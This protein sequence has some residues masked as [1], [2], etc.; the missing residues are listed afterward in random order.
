MNAETQA[1]TL[2]TFTW[3]GS[4]QSGAK[5]KGEMNAINASIIKA[6]LQ[7]QGIEPTRIRKKSK[8]LFT[9]RKRNIK[10]TEVMLFSRHLATMVTAGLPLV[11]ALDTV[12]RG[13]ENPSMQTLIMTI[14]AD[15]EGG[16]TF[17]DA[18]KQHPKQFDDLFCNLISAGEVSGT[19]DVML[20][21][22]ATYQEKSNSLKKKVKKAMYYPITILLVA[23]VVTGVLLVFVVPQF[24]ELFS[25]FGASLPA[26]TQMVLSLSRFLQSYWFAVFGG[27][28]ALVF[29]FKKLKQRSPRFVAWL[30]A[31]VLKM[32][33][34]GALVRKVISARITRTLSITIAAGIPIIDALKA[35]SDTAGNTVYR[36]ACLQI[37]ENVGTGQTLH[38]AME[39]TQLFSNMVTQ[40]VAVGEESGSLEDMLEKVADYYEEDVDN[41]VATL[42]TLLEPIILL[43]LGV[44]IGGFVVAM[45]LPI[46]KLGSVF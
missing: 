23:V 39:S 14:K 5:L 13:H 3:K 38:I 11:Q 18:L 44:L 9:S 41:A 25:S 17:S 36:D 15:I 45:Y 21:Q 12:G 8:S 35:V 2:Q 20:K 29:I 16:H 32:G 26:F 27:I 46:F 42:S 34:I 7:R 30:D 19:L 31:S 40:M 1:Q 37:R 43:I 4:N 10:F 24:E 28:V 6:E 33:A 22:I